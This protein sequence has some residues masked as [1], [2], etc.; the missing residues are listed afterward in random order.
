MQTTRWLTGLLILLAML[1]A[2]CHGGGSGGIEITQGPPAGMT[3]RDASVVYAEGQA[4]IPDTPSSSGGTITQYSVFPPLPAGLSLN[5]QTGAITGTPITVSN[6]T[7]Y[8]VTG[9][10]A[11]GSDT[12]LVEIEVKPS[13]V[14]PDS[15]T[16]LDDSVIY[17]THA[18]ITPNTPTASGGEITQYSVSPALPA[19]LALDPQT[20]IISGTP[21]AVTSPA[22][23]TVTGSNSVDSVQAQVDIEV[24]AQLEPP[25]GLIYM[26]PVPV[27]T[28]GR[29]IDYNDPLYSGGEITQFSVS[30]TLPPGLSMDV[31]TGGISGTPTAT[32]AQTTF[33][34]T[35]SNG[36]GSVT[37]QVAIT[38][39]T[40][41]IGEWLP[42]DAMNLGRYQHTAT[43]LPDGQVLV[44]A[45]YNKRALT[46][47]ELYDPASDTWSQ[48][49]NLVVPREL[50]TATL[51]PNGK[52]LVAGGYNNG[53]GTSQSSAEL[54]DPAT[55]TWSQTGGM[56]QARDSHTATLLSNGMVLVAGGEGNAGLLSSAE[57]YDPATGTWSQTGNLLVQRQ[58]HTA[59]LLP[60]G[61]V[62]VAGGAG[63][64]GRLSSA[65]LYDPATGTWSQTGSLGQVR[66]IY[67]ATLLPDG[68][69]LAAGGYNGTAALSTAELYDPATGTWSQTGSM[70]QA[71]YYLTATLV[72][73][74]RVLV[75]GGIAQRTLASDELYDPATGTW[76]RTGSLL[77]P[78]YRHTATLLPDGRVL[79]V[80]GIGSNGTVSSAEL[81]H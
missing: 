21:T 1:L 43:V 41:V 71:R 7:E 42:A 5:P 78:R 53:G 66:N 59:T 4:I 62:L 61:K 81:F 23:Y 9:T 76:S 28:I 30:P 50:H 17:V 47:A 60:N 75:A 36:A 48:T 52:V 70:S 51:L 19:G 29:P 40:S 35:G 72:P 69:V 26:D 14:A 57:L 63:S 56:S 24:Q 6:A 12:A 73:D 44:A 68:K 49:G 27:Y 31:Q 37:A 77:Q 55:G 2:G 16:Y 39:A 11:E 32:Q 58:Q 38:V 15:L 64:G 22:V 33:I 10:N 3:E 65:E 18:A 45:G 46:S 54:Y 80:G 8:T 74:G 79:A 20:G 13:A 25:T 34:V 67:A